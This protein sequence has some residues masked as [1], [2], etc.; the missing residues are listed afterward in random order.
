MISVRVTD[1]KME[2]GRSIVTVDRAR[3]YSLVANESVAPG[4]LQVTAL[5]AGVLALRVYVYFVRSQL[6][7]PGR[8]QV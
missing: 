2:G 3:M 1:V 7:R 6:G 8:Y 5:D 4:S